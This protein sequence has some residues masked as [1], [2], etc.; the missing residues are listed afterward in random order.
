VLSIVCRVYCRLK[1][2]DLAVLSRYAPDDATL[3]QLAV[4]PDDYAAWAAKMQVGRDST[5]C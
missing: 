3:Q 5:S 4:S 1:H 2:H